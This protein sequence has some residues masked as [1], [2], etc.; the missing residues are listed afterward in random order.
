MLLQGNQYGGAII[1]RP[2]LFFVSFVS[3]KNVGLPQEFINICDHLKS[4][5]IRRVNIG[6]Q[7]GR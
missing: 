6:R 5:A 7:M 1:P 4:A 2:V 3:Y